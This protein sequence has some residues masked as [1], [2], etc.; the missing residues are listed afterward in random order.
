MPEVQ[1]NGRTIDV[2]TDDLAIDI[3]T[4]LSHDDLFEFIVLLDEFA[5]DYNLT[6]A[7]AEHF[8]QVIKDEDESQIIMD[9]GCP[10]YVPKNQEP[11]KS[12]VA[13]DRFSDIEVSNEQDD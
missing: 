13:S 4:A 12:P 11:V 7:L 10:N 5:A 1:I 9:G 8:A 3:E 6:K 2:D